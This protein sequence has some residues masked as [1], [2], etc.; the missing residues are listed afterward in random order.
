M[1]FIIF[2]QMSSWKKASKVNQKVKLERHQPADRAHLGLLEKRKDY[3]P[4][5][6]NY[7]RKR[8][9]LKKLREQALNR[10][11]DEYY[12]HMVNSKLV[13][14]RHTENKKPDS[15]DTI[16]QKKLMTNRSLSY[17][18]MKHVIELKKAEKLQA[19]L[20][21]VD[22]PISKPNKEILSE[23]LLNNPKELPDFKS[24][25]KANKLKEKSYN[26][27]LKTMERA[28]KLGVIKE[29]M[30]VQAHLSKSKGVTRPTLVAPATKISAPVFKW[31]YERKR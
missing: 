3:I 28:K 30:E 31:K 1:T 4:R 17:V 18:R 13:N 25:L 23:H 20:H 19:Q 5:A 2:F 24:L 16:E 27:L 21:F 7:Q 15:E 22:N 29:K 10:N 12:H 6:R 14:D 9:V 11:P 8:N 26:K